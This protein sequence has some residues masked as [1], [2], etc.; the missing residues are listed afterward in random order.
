M[1]QERIYLP[2]VHVNPRSI[3][4]VPEL[5]LGASHVRQYETFKDNFTDNKHHGK[6]SIIAAHKISRALDYLM[7]L[8]KYKKI[9]KGY[10]GEGKYFKINFVTLTLCSGQVHSD[11]EIMKNIVAP[12]LNYLRKHYGLT[13]YIWR[14]EK[15]K[16]GN[17][18]FHLITDIWI[19]HYD[20]RTSWN[21]YLQN[22]GYISRYR[23]AQIIWH[24]NGFKIREELLPYWPASAQ[25]HAY[26]EGLNNDWNNPNTTDIHS[27]KRIKYLKK[28]LCKYLTKNE[29]RPFTE[30]EVSTC[31]VREILTIDNRLWACSQNIS[32]GK[33][34]KLAYTDSIAQELASLSAISEVKTVISDHYNV[35]YIHVA[36]LKKYNCLELYNSFLQYCKATFI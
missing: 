12:M 7:Y 5:V 19:P 6:V 26:S 1:Q 9:P 11:R 17:L 13:N 10:T 3:S 30:Q 2:F 27:T 23:E 16:N 35:W 4:I 22:L 32:K 25:Y 18:H 21:R 24:R 28:Y 8:S 20:L 15:Q 36:Y 33:G 14:A 31:S 29:N 34:A